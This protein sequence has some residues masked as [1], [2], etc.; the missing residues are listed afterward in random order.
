[1]NLDKL[2]DYNDINRESLKII[3]VHELFANED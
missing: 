3:Q 2:N 1:M